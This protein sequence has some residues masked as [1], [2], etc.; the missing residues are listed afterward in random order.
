MEVYIKKPIS[1]PPEK[2]GWYVFVGNNGKSSMT[3]FYSKEEENWHQP[4]KEWY[5]HYLVPAEGHFLTNEELEEMKRKEVEYR[6]DAFVLSLLKSITVS[7][8]EYIKSIK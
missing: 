1:E 7:R 6:I 5:T 3:N 8:A 4:I 2:A